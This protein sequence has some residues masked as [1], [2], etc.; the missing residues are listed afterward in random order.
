MVKV[1]DTVKWNAGKQGMLSG[2]VTGGE[3]GKRWRIEKGGKRYY[4]PKEDV[5][6]GVVKKAKAPAPAKKAEPKKKTPA[7]DKVTLQTVMGVMAEVAKKKD[8]SST[9]RIDRRVAYTPFYN[10]INDPKYPKRWGINKYRD[11]FMKALNKQGR[12]V[13]KKGFDYNTIREV[14]VSFKESDTESWKKLAMDFRKAMDDELG[15]SVSKKQKNLAEEE[16]LIKKH[17]KVGDWIFTKY[18]TGQYPAK[19]SKAVAGKIV[20]FTDKGIEIKPVKNVE[21]VNYG[22]SFNSLG[23][24]SD[25]GNYAEITGDEIEFKSKTQ[26]LPYSR[27]YRNYKKWSGKTGQ[28]V[29]RN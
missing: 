3:K 21:V 4:V 16:E 8:K 26:V 14:A 11:G 24:Y 12:K 28:L 29:P 25:G 17:F 23:N 20:S 2:K 7:P 10:V 1:G 5:K 15:G 9:V 18:F 6:K 22:G 27:G 13:Q 19:L